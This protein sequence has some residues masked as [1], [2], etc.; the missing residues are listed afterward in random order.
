M[1]VASVL[2]GRVRV[3]DEGLKNGPLA[4]QVADALLD[5][6][7]VAKAQA[8]PRVGSLLVLFDAALVAAERILA[9]IA[10]LLGAEQPEPGPARAAEVPWRKFSISLP[11]AA[12]RR[13]VNLGMLA[14]LALS[15]AA[16]VF[17]F[18]KLH[19]LAGILFLALFGDHLF[20]RKE[21]MFA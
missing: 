4:A 13:V 1:V 11:P 15:M 5:T 2:D 6:P 16:A 3:R 20:Q 9:T 19:I 14:S 12:R 7:G 8:N 21:A 18:K 17:D 10:D